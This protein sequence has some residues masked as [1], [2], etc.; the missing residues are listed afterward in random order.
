MLLF[1][2]CWQKT[3]DSF[4]R[5]KGLYYSQHAS[6]ASTVSI[7]LFTALLFTPQVPQR[8]CRAAQI[9]ATLAVGLCC[10][11][12]TLS[13]GTDVFYSTQQAS[14]LFDLKGDSASSFKAAHYKQFRETAWI[15]RLSGLAFLAHPVRPVGVGES[16]SGGLSSQ[17]KHD[18][19]PFGKHW[20]SKSYRASK[21]RHVALNNIKNHIH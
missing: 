18:A 10:K 12:Q 1:H 19:W 17:Q 5:D 4:V 2:E 8:W 11:W 21:C 14:L 13:L 16:P 15:K 9:D 7:N 3:W 6:T 20:F